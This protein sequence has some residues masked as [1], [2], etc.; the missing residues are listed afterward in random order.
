M[1]NLQPLWPNIGLCSCN[2]VIRVSTSLVSKFR[3]FRLA[4][5]SFSAVLSHIAFDT[6]LA[7]QLYPGGASGF[8]IFSPFLVEIVNFSGYDWLFLE[9]LAFGIVG[10]VAFLN[11][12]VKGKEIIST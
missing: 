10:I 9:I 5:I 8:P 12:R 3:D 2:S 11:R 4:A 6:W 7:G 1:P